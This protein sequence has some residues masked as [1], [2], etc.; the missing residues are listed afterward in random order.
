MKKFVIAIVLFFAAGVS[1]GLDG[2]E[3]MNTMP[4]SNNL[5]TKK[6]Y[7]QVIYYAT[8]LENTKERR[9]KRQ[10][11]IYNAEIPSDPIKKEQHLK[12]V[13]EENKRIEDAIE[14]LN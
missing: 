14:R 9:E 3:R 5:L 6:Q 13:D 8:Q 4:H 12:R 2:E 7:E 10:R 1:L 11:E